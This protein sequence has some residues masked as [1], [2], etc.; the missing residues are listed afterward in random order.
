[1]QRVAVRSSMSEVQWRQGLCLTA[2][3]IVGPYQHG[4]ADSL[5]GAGTVLVPVVA[6]GT[7]WKRWQAKARPP[8]ALP[9]GNRHR[10]ALL[11]TGTRQ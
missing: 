3:F 2:T 10:Q 11:V 5:T 8:S 7:H 1:M 6:L 4:S 9:L